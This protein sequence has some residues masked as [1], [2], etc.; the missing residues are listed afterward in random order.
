MRDSI[1]QR[2]EEFIKHYEK[3]LQK[4]GKAETVPSLRAAEQEIA[5]I[6][7]YLGERLMGTYSTVR[8]QQAAGQMKRC[9]CGERLPVHRWTHWGHGTLHADL[10]VADPYGYCRTCGESQRPLHGLLGMEPQR[11]SRAVQR[12]AVDFGADHSFG[13]S[14][15]KMTEHYPNTPIGASSL[16]DLV[17]DHGRTAFTYIEEKLQRAAAAGLEKPWLRVGVEHLEVEHD[18]SYI[19][20]GVLQAID[21][22]GQPPKRT[23][24]RGHEKRRRQTDWKQINLGSAHERGSVSAWYCGRF[25]ETEA[26]FDDLFGLGCLTGWSMNTHTTGIADGARTIRPNLQARFQVRRPDH[27][28]VA[29]PPQS[30]FKFILDRPHV[31]RHLV[32]AGEIVAPSENQAVSTWV[33]GKLQQIDRGGVQQVVAA[34]TAAAQAAQSKI[35]QDQADYLERNADAVDYDRFQAEGYSISSGVV[36][37]AHGHVIQIRMKQPGMWWHPDNVDPMVALRLLRVNHWWDEYWHAQEAADQQ[38]AEKL[39][40]QHQAALAA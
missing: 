10:T 23:P 11:W 2:C 20:T 27:V 22:G 12:A 36:E 15:Q 13:K 32:L 9:G 40:H 33:D 6:K 31:R 19:R 8:S 34:L 26:A 3:A 29:G 37:S 25:G 21:W 24:V 16:R 38:K 5:E 1:R 18:G 14:A 17:L 4:D 39:R 7:Q 28:Q 35:V 30:G